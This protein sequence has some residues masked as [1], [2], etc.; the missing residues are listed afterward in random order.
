MLLHVELSFISVRHSQHSCFTIPT[1]TANAAWNALAPTFWKLV[2]L[3]YQA[4]YLQVSLHEVQSYPQHLV[5]KKEL[6]LKS[7]KEV[8]KVL[9]SPINDI[10]CVPVDVPLLFPFVSNAKLR[11]NKEST[12]WRCVGSNAKGGKTCTAASVTSTLSSPSS[13]SAASVAEEAAVR[14]KWL[15]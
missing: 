1:L 11:P 2:A 9:C 7:Y 3:L 8:S 12:G 6:F 13:G 4:K 5:F 15:C 14:A 10:Y